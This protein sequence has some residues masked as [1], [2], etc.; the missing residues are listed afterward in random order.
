MRRGRRPAAVA[1]MGAVAAAV[2]G[3][4]PA[5]AVGVPSA[6]AQMPGFL[7]PSDMPP[8]PFSDWYGSSGPSDGPYSPLCAET[9]SLPQENVW[10]A[11]YSTPETAGGSQVTVVLPTEAEAVAFGAQVEAAVAGCEA[12]MEQDQPNRPVSFW[13]HGQLSVE[14]GAHVYGIGFQGGWGYQ[15]QLVSVGRDGNTVTVVSWE[16]NWGD[17]PVDAFKA[18]TVT[19]VNKLH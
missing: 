4:T 2:L 8:D 10:N 15:N 7:D 1:V 13:D 18:T 6:V 9:V 14:E 3:A 11:T 5:G 12:R 17:P 19:A 16:S